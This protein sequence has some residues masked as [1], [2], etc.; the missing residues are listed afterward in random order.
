MDNITPVALHDD[1]FSDLREDLAKATPLPV[2]LVADENTYTACGRLAEES[3]R[4]A[5]LPMTRVILRGEGGELKADERAIALV[6]KALRGET[7]RLVA[8]GAGTI[9]D[10]VRFTAFQTRLPFLSIPS[11]V[12]VDAFTSYTAAITIGKA[13]YSIGAKPPEKVYAHLP[14]LCAAPDCLTASGFG[15]MLAKLTALADWQLAHLLVDET[16]PAEIADPMRAAARACARQAEEIKV[17]S[18]AGIRTLMESMCLSGHSMVAVR[19]SRPA[20]GAEHSLAHFWEMTHRAEDGPEP[21]HGEKTGCATAIIARLYDSLRALSKD[22]ARQRLRAFRLPDP[23][24][25]T[26]RILSAYGEIGQSLI[27]ERSHLYSSLGTKAESIAQ[28]L[29]ERW[30]EAQA[31]AASV[32]APE[33][34]IAT[35]DAAGAVSRPEQIGIGARE[36]RDAVRYG[37]YARE[38][39]TILE[40]NQMLQLDE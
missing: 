40:L 22:E 19:S 38:R 36:V 2:L 20:A 33:E 25:E 3:L 5:G 18:P 28:R 21:M 26:Q 35:L 17:H 32:P 11:A 13:K 10:I 12:S 37:T 9:T 31:I 4:A 14:T 16:Y 7:Q 23:A 29:I 1:V 6:L 30:D 8:V 27:A 15:D 39:F 24:E 34:I